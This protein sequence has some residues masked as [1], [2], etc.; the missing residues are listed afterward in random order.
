MR[1]IFISLFFA[2]ITTSCQSDAVQNS[3]TSY[4]NTGIDPH[5]F[6]IMADDLGLDVGPCHSDV[7]YMPNLQF[8]CEN[9]LIFNKAYSNASCAPTRASL[10]TGRHT[11]RHGVNDVVQTIKKLPLSE[12]T[13]P[14]WISQLAPKYRKAA[15]GKWHL[16]DDENGGVNNPNAQGFDHYEG[17]PRQ[18]GTYNYFE[19]DWYINGVNKGKEKTY[20][21]TKITNAAIMDFE[22]NNETP[23]FYFVN[24]VNPHLPY[25]K[26]PADLHNVS[27]PAGPAAEREK[28]THRREKKLDPYY[29]AMLE[30]LDTEINRLVTRTTAIS[31]KPIV[32]IFL[33]DNGSAQNVYRGDISGGYRAKAS[34]YEGGIRIPL[35]IWSSDNERFPIVS[36]RTDAFVHVVD[37]F[38]TITHI[39]RPGSELPSHKMDSQS[40]A[41]VLTDL[42][43]S[44]RKNLYIEKG[45]PRS[46]PFSYASINEAGK[47]LILNETERVSKI[48]PGVFMEYYDT[49]K[50]PGERIN[51]LDN[52]CRVNYDEV[53]DLLDFLVIKRG[54]E[55]DPIG[56]VF[57][58]AFYRKNIKS[59]QS[60]C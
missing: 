42:S 45:N 48:N 23:Q 20:K 29:F 30:S 39:I 17:T 25:H 5:I 50:D 12:V 27:L 2:I 28:S 60:K 16:A 51:L 14:E 47:K 15:F 26:P 46:N 21:T 9:S 3:A 58:E 38:A 34:L 22:S 6:I 44:S 59:L 33:G 41:P 56:S 52:P 31:N 10:M 49:Q 11:F 19:Y 43:Y 40:F 32:F 36:G 7:T 1:L 54:T 53:H 35:Q 13:L 24:Y 18:S 8:R 37:F 55:I 57:N 4:S